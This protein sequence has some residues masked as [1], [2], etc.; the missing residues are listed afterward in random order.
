MRFYRGLF[1]RCSSG[2]PVLQRRDGIAE[3]IGAQVRVAD[4]PLDL[5]LL[6]VFVIEPPVKLVRCEARGVHCEIALDGLERETALRNQPGQGN[7]ALT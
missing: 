2:L 5:P 6:S 7:Y 1:H 4:A 3:P